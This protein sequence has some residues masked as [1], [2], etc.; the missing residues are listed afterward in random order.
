MLKIID[1]QKNSANKNMQIDESLLHNIQNKPILHFYE[2]EKLSFT[3]GYFVD[4]EKYVDIKKAKDI[5]FDFSKRP[6][7][8]G[9]VFHIWDIAFSFIMPSCNNSY[10][11]DTLRNYK[12]VNEITLNAIKGYLNNISLKEP[13][14][15]EISS[16]SD[17]FCMAN[18]TK[19][20]LI[21]KGKKIL[22]AAQRR[23]KNGYLHQSSIS[24]IK[25]DKTLLDD[26]L[27]NKQVSDLILQSS[28]PIF[29]NGEIEEIRVLI[30]NSL[31]KEFIKKIS[32]V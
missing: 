28:Y 31:I 11:I 26:V 27:K 10:F 18:P 19:Y 1:T 13:I 25:P 16:I 5:G 2:F 32:S 24:L 17:N 22:G 23:G 12:F 6:T 20:D 21:Y 29:A 9:I 14:S 3:Y 8:G 4:I 7:G 15:K 30:K